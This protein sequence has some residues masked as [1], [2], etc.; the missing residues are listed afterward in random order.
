MA[1]SEFAVTYDGPA[2]AGGR[3]PVRDLAPALLALGDLFAEAS[4]MAYP[5]REPV[6]LDIKATAEGSFDVQ[7]VLQAGAMWDTLVE[8]F[9]SDDAAALAHIKELIFGST[10]GLFFLI[11]WLRGRRVKAQEQIP[12]RSVKLT[13]DDNTSMTVPNEVLR[14]YQRPNIQRNARRFVEPLSREGVESVEVRVA[15]ETSLRLEAGDI[16]AFPEP[17]E[18]PLVD[19]EMQMYVAIAAV[20]FVEGNK[21]RFSSGDD[22]FYAAVEDQRFLEDIEQGKAFRKGDVLRCRM[23]LIQ[24][25]RNGNL[26]TERRVVEVMEHIPREVQLGLDDQ[27]DDG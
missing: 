7:L 24:T 5:D 19:H 23:R 21:W 14:L 25:Q 17:E 11:R 1:E 27:A 18:V 12:P 2:V 20:A 10:A 15:N 26:H 3:M 13:L 9:S 8:L 6:V 16:G 4:V 22:T